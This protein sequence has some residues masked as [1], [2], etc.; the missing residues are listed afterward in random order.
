MGGGPESQINTW[1]F[2]RKTAHFLKKIKCSK[3]PK[4]QNKLN[5][6]LSLSGVPNALGGWV[7]SDVWDKVPNKTVFLGPSLR[8][9]PPTTPSTPK[10]PKGRCKKN[11]FI[12]D[13]V[14]NIGPHPPTAHVWDSTKWKM[15]VGFILLFG[16]FGAFY[17]LFKKQILRIGPN[18]KESRAFIQV[19]SSHKMSWINPCSDKLICYKR[20][21][22]CVIWKFHCF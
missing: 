11:V 4:K 8:C 16:L 7:G 19:T 20:M 2:V 1:N 21:W 18:T 10:T 15:K 3:Q 5:F 17:F 9:C 14:P 12:W 6:Y 13:F 22:L